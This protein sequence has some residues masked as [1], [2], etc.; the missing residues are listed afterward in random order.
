MT[1]V[2]GGNSNT[3]YGHDITITKKQQAIIKEDATVELDIIGVVEV[4]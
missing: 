3:T 1:N 4:N 2:R